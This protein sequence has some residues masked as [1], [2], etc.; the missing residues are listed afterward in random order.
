MINHNALRPSKDIALTQVMYRQRKLA[1]DIL[2]T[3]EGINIDS[4]SISV[5]NSIGNSALLFECQSK[6][7]VEDFLNLMLRM[8]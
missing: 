5:G 6:K 4:Y 1:S 8:K 2:I 7:D 3:Q